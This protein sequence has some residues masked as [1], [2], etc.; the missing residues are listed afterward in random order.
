MFLP[1]GWVGSV[2]GSLDLPSDRCLVT[3]GSTGFRGAP[4]SPGKSGTPQPDSP[5]LVMGLYPGQL[6]WV[7]EGPP[8]A[9]K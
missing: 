7:R 5:S 8:D 1:G 9:V 6:W 3:A 4:E 2:L